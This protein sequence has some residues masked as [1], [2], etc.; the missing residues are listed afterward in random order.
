MRDST[1]R[2]VCLTGQLESI[3][4]FGH[5]LTPGRYVEAVN[6]EDD[7]VSFKERFGSLSEQL[8][9]QFRLGQSLEEPI[10][11][12]IAMVSAET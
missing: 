6:V 10:S 2:S 3:A 8:S 1:A 9:S 7:G 4:K 5:G 11:K 12:T